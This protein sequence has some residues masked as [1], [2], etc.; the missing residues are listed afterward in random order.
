MGVQSAC[1][2][3][4]HQDE[5]L[6]SAITLQCFAVPQHG[7]TFSTVSFVQNEMLLSLLKTVSAHWNLCYMSYNA[8]CFIGGPF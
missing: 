4:P 1:S 6:L 5:S 8:V 7:E 2:T 3:V